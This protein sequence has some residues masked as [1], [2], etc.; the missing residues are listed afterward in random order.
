MTRLKLASM[1]LYLF[2]VLITVAMGIKFLTASEYFVYHAQAAGMDW[3][4]VDPGL[5]VVFLAVFKVCGAGF[6]TVS[7]CMLLMIVFPFAKHTRGWSVYAIPAC[8]TLF[9]SIVL[10]ATAYVASTTPAATPW[11]GSLF[12]VVVILIAFVLSLAD[13][14]KSPQQSGIDYP[15]PEG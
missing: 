1:V 14:S 7:L 9:W 15:A 3:A 10:A 6:L 13:R 11:S 5:Q 2:V 4:A 12:N 8:G